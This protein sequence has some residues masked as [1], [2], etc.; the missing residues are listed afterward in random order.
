VIQRFVER[1]AGMPSDSAAASALGQRTRAQYVILG[2]VAR[3]GP[4]TVSVRAEVFDL[5]PH[6][7]LQ[8]TQVEKTGSPNDLHALVDSVTIGLLY[9]LGQS[10]AITE[11]RRFPLGTRS[12]AAL[13]AFVQ[14][15]RHY[16]ASAWD[17]AIANYEHAVDGDSTF[18][19]ALRRIGLAMSWQRDALDSI[20]RDYLLRA[21]RHNHGLALRDSLLV[22]ADSLRASLAS[23]AF[24]VDTAYSARVRR[25]FKTL[26]VAIQRNSADS[27]AWYSLGDAFFHYGFGPVSANGTEITDRRMLEAFNRAIELDSGFGPAYIHAVELALNLEDA[28]TARRYIR[29][30]LAL[31]PSDAAAEGIRVVDAVTQPRIDGARE[32]QTLLDTVSAEALFTAWAALRRWP[33]SAETALRVARLPLD[34]R[35]TSTEPSDERRRRRQNLL[36]QLAHNGHLREV[37][38]TLGG[39]LAPRE[40]RLFSELGLMGIVPRDTVATVFARWLHVPWMTDEIGYPPPGV[41]AWWAAQNDSASLRTFRSRADSVGRSATTLTAIEARNTEFSPPKPT[42]RSRAVIRQMRFD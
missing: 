39:S 30:Y 25:L 34:R 32:V 24:E 36:L 15:E 27:E 14:G 20:S 41:L 29:A 2:R 1:T 38:R 7:V 22:V 6:A 3:L 5:D 21:G 9:G 17:A 37:Y 31:K 19:L 8:T 28:V 13:S 40:Y 10:G 16:R 26:T 35:R 33:D 23:S 11:L 42:S 12:I 18:A 4:Q